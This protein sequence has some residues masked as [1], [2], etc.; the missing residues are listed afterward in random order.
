MLQP[1]GMIIARRQTSVSVAVL[2][3]GW[4]RFSVSVSVEVEFNFDFV[5]SLAVFLFFFYQIF[6]DALSHVF[7]FFLFLVCG[8]TVREYLHSTRGTVWHRWAT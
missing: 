7:F 3:G 5:F 6:F 1:A 4:L 8:Q 2:V